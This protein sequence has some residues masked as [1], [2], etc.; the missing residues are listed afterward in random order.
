MSCVE[1]G[2]WWKISVQIEKKLNIK[3]IDKE[4]PMVM[5]LISDL[6]YN[7]NNIVSSKA[8]LQ[9]SSQPPK[10]NQNKHDV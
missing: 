1:N 3:S 8:K 10:T 9:N 6:P 4:L 2:L 7:Y 5:P